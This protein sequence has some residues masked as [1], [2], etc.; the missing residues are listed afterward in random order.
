MYNENKRKILVEAINGTTWFSHSS[1]IVNSNI[2]HIQSISK[3]EIQQNSHFG[4]LKY[5]FKSEVK[6]NTKP[7]PVQHLG[8]RHAI[9]AIVSDV[10]PHMKGEC[11]NGEADFKREYLANQTQYAGE[12][13]WSE[14]KC[15]MLTTNLLW[16]QIDLSR[17]KAFLI[18][19]VGFR[20]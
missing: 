12:M 2:K 17:M 9:T 5:R 11:L 10:K 3:C 13:G 20:K 14:I 4:H 15:G 1:S 16:K 7:K 6:K 18:S 8:K 19:E